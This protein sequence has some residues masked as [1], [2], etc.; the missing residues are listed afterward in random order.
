[1][2]GSFLPILLRCALGIL[3]VRHHTLLTRAC[4]L[5]TSTLL[6]LFTPQVGV[7]VYQG[8]YF[9]NIMLRCMF[10]HKV[11]H[12]APRNMLRSMTYQRCWST[13]V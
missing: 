1:M 7:L 10:G 9:V 6:T 11:R 8:G 4:F 5:R 2:W 13:V 12:P 3:W